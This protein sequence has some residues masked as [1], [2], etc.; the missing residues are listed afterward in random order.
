MRESLTRGSQSWP[1]LCDREV[2]PFC[3]PSLTNLSITDNTNRNAATRK[4]YL[5]VCAANGITAR[6]VQILY[7]EIIYVESYCVDVS[8]SLAQSN[9]HGT[10]TFIEPLTYRILWLPRKSASFPFHINI[11]LI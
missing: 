1:E 8:I 10:I 9:L 3:I 6:E 4:P 5:D 7:K 11:L 2:L